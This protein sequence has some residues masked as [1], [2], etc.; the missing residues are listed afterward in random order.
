MPL[1][2]KKDDNCLLV[3]VEYFDG[4]ILDTLTDIHS[5]ILK[6]PEGTSLTLRGDGGADNWKSPQEAIPPFSMIESSIHCLI[7]ETLV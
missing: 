2:A 1:A 4:S 6:I 7:A 5:F 3:V